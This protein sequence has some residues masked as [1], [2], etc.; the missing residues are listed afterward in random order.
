METSQYHNQSRQLRSAENVTTN[1]CVGSTIYRFSD[2]FDSDYRWFVR[3][4]NRQR[5]SAI[6]CSCVAVIAIC[7]DSIYSAGGVVVSYTFNPHSKRVSKIRAAKLLNARLM[8]V[9]LRLVQLGGFALAIGL[10]FIDFTLMWFTLAAVSLALVLAKW[11]DGALNNLQPEDLDSEQ[12][13]QVVSA[14]LLSQLKGDVTKSDDF[15][16]S[17]RGSWAMGFYANNFKLHPSIIDPYI[18]SFKPE[19]IQQVWQR[20]Q[21]LAQMQQLNSVTGAAVIVSLFDLIADAPQL[22]AQLGL[23]RDDLIAGMLWQH[24]IIVS[25]DENDSQSVASFGR[26]WSVGYTPLLD[27]FAQN[28]SQSVSL[29]V[30]RRETPEHRELIKQITQQFAKNQRSIVAVIGPAGSGKTRLLHALAARLQRDNAPSEVKNWR[31]FSVG[32][33]SLLTKLESTQQGE[34]VLQQLFV[35]T[36]KAGASL[37]VFDD[38]EKLLSQQSD[39]ASLAS[40]FETLL[41]R[42]SAPVLLTFDA[43]AW[44]RLKAE[45]PNLVSSINQLT[46]GSLVDDSTIVVLED[47]VPRLQHQYNVI[48]TYQALKKAISLSNRYLTDTAQPGRSLKLLE[49]AV[50]HAVD[51]VV[52]S[53]AVASSVEAAQGVKVQ[54]TDGAEAEQLLNLEEEIH[55]RLVNQSRAVSAVAQALRRA[56][57]GVSSRSRAMGTFLFLGPTGVGKTELARALSAIMFSSEDSMV[58]IDMNEFSQPGSVERLL[59][60]DPANTSSL[61]A[62]I[63]RQPYSVVLFDEIEKA[64]SS[65]QNTLLQLLDEGVMRDAANNEVSFRDAIIIAT[66]NAGANQIRRA[67]SDGKQVEQFEHDFLDHLVDSGQFKPEFLNRFDEAVVFRPLT[68]EELVQVVDI[69]MRGVNRQLSEQQITVSLTEDAKHWLAK[70]GYDPRLGARPLRRVIQKT[71]ESYVADEILRGTIQPGQQVQLNVQHLQGS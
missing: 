31:V 15:W 16:R 7:P 24:H 45:H 48:V 60:A 49:S 34:K 19:H 26:E 64:D 65:V 6:D 4:D 38:A 11:R 54:Q 70:E 50:N 56:R 5:V 71:V 67:I 55:Q 28:L 61:L 27:R 46:M 20:A 12:L 47:E 63:K 57:S 58:R 22:L 23:T 18:D 52:D 14:K 51:G 43:T 9:L 68:E 66:S 62:K 13:D 40:V 32:V 29:K 1:R 2:S 21:Q 33:T 35:E 3:A 17:I 30:W 53:A 10:G 59:D 44:Q 69:L 41:S 37:L 39:G 8:H 25:L 42:S 36:N